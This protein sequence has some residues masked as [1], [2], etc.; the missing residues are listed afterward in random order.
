MPSLRKRA[1]GVLSLFISADGDECCPLKEQVG[2]ALR[3]E[4][5]CRLLPSRYTSEDKGQGR[6]TYDIVL[7]KKFVSDCLLSEHDVV[8]ELH[9]NSIPCLTEVAGLPVSCRMRRYVTYIDY[10][11]FDD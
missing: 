3:E 7:D 4:I 10:L 2:I 8:D 6:S 1:S 5:L 11:V 9:D